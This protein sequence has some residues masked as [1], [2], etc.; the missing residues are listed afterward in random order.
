MLLSMQVY[1]RDLKFDKFFL[2]QETKLDYS[3]FFVLLIHLVFL[4]FVC[5]HSKLLQLFVKYS[6]RSG[7]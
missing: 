4:D 5:S 2:Q 1:F 3:I 7:D 6:I